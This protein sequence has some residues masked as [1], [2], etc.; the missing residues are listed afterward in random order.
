MKLIH[1][2]HE[3]KVHGKRFTNLGA[4]FHY[5]IG[6]ATQITIQRWGKDE[7]ANISWV[8]IY[9]NV[10]ANNGFYKLTGEAWKDAHRILTSIEHNQGAKT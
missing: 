1:K 5:D 10:S 6:G 9:G 7:V 3:H 2:I 4:G 8:N